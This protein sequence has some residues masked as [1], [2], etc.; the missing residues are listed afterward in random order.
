MNSK[1]SIILFLLFMIFSPI[2]S[3]AIEENESNTIDL[4]EPNNPELRTPEDILSH[5]ES[6]FEKSISSHQQ[7]KNRWL[8]IINSNYASP[9]YHS[10]RFVHNGQLIPFG[11]ILEGNWQRRFFYKDT[12]EDKFLYN[13]LGTIRSAFLLKYSQV[14]YYFIELDYANEIQYYI[15][16]KQQ[17]Q[18][19]NL[20]LFYQ[21][22]TLN[23]EFETY[24]FAR[25]LRLYLTKLGEDQKN[26]YSGGIGVS[27]RTL[28]HKTPNYEIRTRV[29][30]DRIF[31]VSDTSEGQIN[32]LNRIGTSLIGSVFWQI[33]RWF[34]IEAGLRSEFIYS[35]DTYNH[36]NLGLPVSLVFKI[37][38]GLNIRL[39]SDRYLQ[40][41]DFYTPEGIDYFHINNQQLNNHWQEIPFHFQE[42]IIYHFSDDNSLSFLMEQKE[43][44]YYNIWELNNENL[45]ISYNIPKVLVYNARI[46]V[47]NKLGDYFQAKLSAKYNDYYNIDYPESKIPYTTEIEGEAEIKIITPWR[48]EFNS[49][50]NYVGERYP[51]RDSN[52]EDLL[53]SYSY[54]DIRLG[55]ALGKNL[56]F[57]I[58]IENVLDKHYDIYTGYK[59]P[60]RQIHSG[61]KITF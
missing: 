25:R 30:G 20:F 44:D 3:Y 57:Y 42:E 14:K 38:R 22:R 31:A 11:Y 26:D 36:F 29:V 40:I 53:A 54:W 5:S 59:H 50:I 7:L 1:N 45:P 48:Q 58:E 55:Q 10:G 60:G 37:G 6:P 18:N 23:R 4:P 49:S 47:N 34:F 16:Q 9:Q 51:N 12:F 13:I 21:D 27:F 17:A 33:N 52:K 8:T 19:G 41:P 32:I 24:V 43:I 61:M 2:V 15:S 39:A 46:M 28:G 35:D 56:K